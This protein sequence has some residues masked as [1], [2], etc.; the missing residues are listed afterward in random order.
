LK[1]VA[2]QLQVLMPGETAAPGTTTGKTG[3]PTAQQAGVSFDITVNAVDDTWHLINTVTDTVTIT[4]SD[5]GAALP[6]DAALVKGTGTFSVTFG[7]A[8]S[9]TVTASDV[10]DANK[11]PNTGTSTTVNP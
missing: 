8:G 1:R 6:T 7:S 2:S 11:K 4:T 10:T 5:P 3:A 9:Y